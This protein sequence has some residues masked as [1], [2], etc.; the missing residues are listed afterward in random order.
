MEWSGVATLG[1][2]PSVLVINYLAHRNLNIL[3]TFTLQFL[4]LHLL[5]SLF[6]CVIAFVLCI[7]FNLL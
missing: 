7:N 3:L 1:G 2:R 6:I 5:S 4:S